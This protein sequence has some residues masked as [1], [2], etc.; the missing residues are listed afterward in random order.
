MTR[1][2][3][4]KQNGVIPDGE[5][6]DDLIDVIIGDNAT[7]I[8]NNALTNTINYIKRINNRNINLGVNATTGKIVTITY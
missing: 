1:F 4:L 8:D 5:D 6:L 7:R 3:Q 2:E